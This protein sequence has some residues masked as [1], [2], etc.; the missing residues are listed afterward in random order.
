MVSELDLESLQARR[1]CKN[2][3]V[4]YEILKSVS[5]KYVSNIIPTTTKRCALRNAILFGKN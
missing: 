1:R 2:L 5:P 3:G 4:L